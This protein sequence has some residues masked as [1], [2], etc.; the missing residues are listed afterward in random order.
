MSKERTANQSQQGQASEMNS[1]TLKD[2]PK[3]FSENVIIVIGENTIEVEKESSVM[4]KENLKELIKNEPIIKNDPELLESN[5]RTYNLILV[6]TPT[7][8]YILQEAYKLTNATRVTNEYPGENKGILEILG[9]PWNSNKALLLIAGSDEWGVKTG[10]RLL[11]YAQD[12]NKSNVV[13]EWKESKA[14]FSRTISKDKYIFL[15]VLQQEIIPGQKTWP[16]ES[17]HE[18]GSYNFDKTTG[19]LKIHLSHGTPSQYKRLKEEFTI[20]DDLTVVVGNKV[21]VRGVNDWR[22]GVKLVY[23]IPSFWEIA[24]ELKF[25]IIY[26]EGN[27]AIY[28]RYKNRKIILR[29]KEEYNM[30]FKE[31][32]MGQDVIRKV[33]IKN[34]GLQDK[35]KIAVEYHY[36]GGVRPPTPREEE[37]LKTKR[38]L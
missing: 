19:G 22:E 8:N 2:Y 5:K 6:G 10:S 15:E 14:I 33:I 28:L 38:R 26:S 20:N 36:K 18:Q 35:D 21:V 9:S 13:V 25:E 3:L 27:G 4:I 16:Q 37:F 11:K 32:W 17:F 34:H 30:Q 7:T 12:I 29:P 24:F 23:I 1:L 31:K